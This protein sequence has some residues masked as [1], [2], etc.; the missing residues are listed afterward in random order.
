[1]FH[2]V[3]PYDLNDYFTN[4][5]AAIALVTATFDHEARTFIYKNLHQRFLATTHGEEEDMASEGELFNL[6]REKYE[7]KLW[8]FNMLIFNHQVPEFDEVTDRK[9]VV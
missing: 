9:S 1:M 8:E 7:A 3:S 2:E 6:E 4:R 5:E